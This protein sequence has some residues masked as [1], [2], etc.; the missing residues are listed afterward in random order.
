MILHRHIVTKTRVRDA[1]AR[2]DHTTFA[3]HGFAFD[4]D[5]RMDDRVAPDLSVGADVRVRRIDKRHATLNHQ[6]SNRR[7]ANK[8]LNPRGLGARI[9]SRTP[10]RMVNEKNTDGAAT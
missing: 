5:V 3:D 10:T 8:V 2:A 1:G 7:T 6:P 9:H 4:L